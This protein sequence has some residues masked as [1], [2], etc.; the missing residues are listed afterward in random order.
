MH[1]VR[2]WWNCNFFKLTCDCAYLRYPARMTWLGTDWHC[3]SYIG[4]KWWNDVATYPGT[5][6]CLM[7]YLVHAHMYPYPNDVLMCLCNKLHCMVY[8]DTKG[9]CMT[10]LCTKWRCMTYFCSVPNEVVHYDVPMYQMTLYDVSMNQMTL[11]DV[12]L[13][14]K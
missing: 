5:K 1:G 14:T 11:Y 2:E 8:L 4:T 7:S 10:Y 13:C 9:Y 6:W 3:T 12:P